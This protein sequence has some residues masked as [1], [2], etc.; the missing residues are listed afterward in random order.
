[1][2]KSNLASDLF[3]CSFNSCHPFFKKEKYQY[4]SFSETELDSGKKKK[5]GYSASL[6]KVQVIL[7]Q[8]E[9]FKLKIVLN[10]SITNTVTGL[11]T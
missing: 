2:R 8:F 4:S 6:R 1:M 11:L 5:K 9:N 10:D 7:L 3:Q